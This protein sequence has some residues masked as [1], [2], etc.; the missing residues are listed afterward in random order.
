[1][2]P[3]ANLMAVGE[4]FNWFMTMKVVVLCVVLAEE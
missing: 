4:Q 2:F 1:M 3:A